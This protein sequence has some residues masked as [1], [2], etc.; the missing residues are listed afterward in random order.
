MIRMLSL[1]T[2]A[3]MTLSCCQ[4]R[5]TQ[6]PEGNWVPE[7][8]AKLTQM[9]KDYGKC[10]KSYDKNAKP[11][12]VFDFDNTSIIN[13]VETSL[14]TYQATFLRYKITPDC[15]FDALTDCLCDVDTVLPDEMTPRMYATDITADYTYLYENYIG[16]YSDHESPEAVAAL[17]EIKKT[18]EYKDFAAKYF[19]LY[20]NVYATF[21]YPTC[22]IWILKPLNGM[23]YDEIQALT[24]ESCRYFMQKEGMKQVVW[25]SP[26]MGLCGK[27]S[28]SHPEGMHVTDEMKNLY[29]TLKANGFDVYICSASHEIIVEAMACDPEFGF[30]MDTDHVIGLRTLDTEDG[31]FNAVYHPDEIGTYMQGKTAAIKALFAPQHGG[32]DPYLVAGDSNGDYN[33]LVDFDDMKVG[34]IINCGNTGNIG[35]LTRSGKPQIA[36]QERD[37]DRGIFVPAI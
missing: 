30:N 34:L 15:M 28:A 31:L 18:D 23:T 32:K 12:A 11:Y 4:N 5:E 27:V 21:D 7:V 36:V 10:S 20:K 33:M 8:H 14:F 9:M 24:R 17:E 1:M 3:A 13:D 22:L 35:E 25:E 6:L 37:T 26:E 16:R 29:A 2:A 19:A